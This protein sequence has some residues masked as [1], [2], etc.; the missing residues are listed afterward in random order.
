MRYHYVAPL[1]ALL[2]ASVLPAQSRGETPAPSGVPGAS[3]APLLAGPQ[4]LTGT[5]PAAFRTGFGNTNNN[6]PISWTPTRYQ[7]VF[8][9]SELPTK[10]AIFGLGFRFDEAFANYKGQTIDMEITLAYTNKTPSTL[11][12][13]YA[14]NFDITTPQPLVVFPRGQFKLPDMPATKPSNPQYWPIQI[15]FKILFVW[16]QQANRN[17]LVEIKVF[18]NSNNN[19]IFTYPL[20]ACSGSTATTTR[21]FS[22]SAT[23]ATGTLGRSYGLVMSFLDKIKTTATYLTWGQ[24][25]QGTGGFPGFILPAAMRTSMGNSDNRYGV[26]QA[27]MR[28]QQVFNGAE[29]GQVRVLTGHSLRQRKAWTGGAQTLEIKISST[30]YTPATLTTTFNTNITSPQTT[31]FTKKSYNY[32]T[33]VL[34]TDPRNFGIDFKWDKNFIWLNKPGENLLLEVVNTS[35]STLNYY[36]D[37]I[38]GN[39]N[40]TRLYATSGPTATTGAIGRSFGLVMRFQYSGTGTSTPVLSNTG[41]PILGKTFSVDLSDARVNTAAGFM[42][43]ASNTSWGA[44]KLPLDL[45]GLNAKGCNLLVSPDLITGVGVGSTGRASVQIPVPNLTSLVGIQWH[46]QFLVLDT[47]AN[48]L[49]MCFTNGGTGKVGEQ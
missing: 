47:Q 24:G 33:S 14:S 34:N 31:V 49:G 5:V 35:T 12:S 32:P 30:T 39:T 19:N 20:D 1:V 3:S 17:M 23:A 6:I 26:A 8:L 4:N 28:Y 21:L 10:L 27:N 11:T 40:V 45:S 44:I 46:N 43:G 42:V 22:G 13:T 18:G 29:I 37:A 2:S 41:T 38:S 9:G 48:G 36:P 16:I 15:P 25:C 7:Q